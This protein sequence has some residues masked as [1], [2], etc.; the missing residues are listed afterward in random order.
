MLSKYEKYKLTKEKI[1]KILFFEK[2]IAVDD[3]ILVSKMAAPA[4]ARLVWG[5]SKLTNAFKILFKMPHFSSEK[6]EFNFLVTYSFKNRKDH[7][8]KL[9]KFL[10]EENIDNS[11]CVFLRSRLP[12]NYKEFYLIISSLLKSLYVCL[13]N[14][15]V[16]MKVII[17]LA[18]AIKSYKYYSSLDI[19]AS[20]Y[21]AYNS[22]DMDETILTIVM[23]EK[24]NTYGL[25]H[26]I[27]CKF[28]NT[29]PIDII[30]YENFSA[31]NAILWGD[32]TLAEIKSYLPENCK[33]IKK[34][35]FGETYT[36]S[37]PDKR[38]ILVL[39]P[40]LQ[41][42][43]NCIQLLEVISS[44][45]EE[46]FL[47]RRHPSLEGKNELMKIVNSKSNIKFTNE[48]SNE[49]MKNSTFKCC[50]SFNSTSLFEALYFGQT[51]LQYISGNDE[52]IVDLIKNF[53][54]EA[55]LRASLMTLDKNSL[56]R[57]YFFEESE[58]KIFGV[59]DES[60]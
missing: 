35:H 2:Y 19:K 4:L 57:R 7:A 34:Y 18:Y 33:I 31:A 54:N 12:K 1:S 47:I 9:K 16:D 29:V 39:L 24:A 30:N 21:I 3:S 49:L 48:P 10:R 45:S 42:L 44:I 11:E 22:A 23:N 6:R 46:D 59:Y 14:N 32:F 25:Q 17:S 36:H 43:V 56:T 5:K 28:N 60:V 55:E 15:I 53:S 37:R 51:P 50:I 20:N 52:F 13:N 38:E 58:E 8:D 27:M 41:Y 26:G 40:R